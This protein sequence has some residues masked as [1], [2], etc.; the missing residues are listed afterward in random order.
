MDKK[1]RI[2]VIGSGIAGLSAAWLL[3]RR[4]AVTLFEAAGYLGGHTNTVDVT[5]D[6]ITAPV[7]TGFLVFNDRTYPQLVRMLDYD[8]VFI[9]AGSHRSIRAARL[10]RRMGG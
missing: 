7:D 1:S 9:L 6:G 8:L 2:A 5:L 4:H 10:L 3:S